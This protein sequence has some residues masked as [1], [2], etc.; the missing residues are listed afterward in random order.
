MRDNGNYNAFR[1]GQKSPETPLRPPSEQISSPRELIVTCLS[2]QQ[3]SRN[4]ANSRPPSPRRD[5][6]DTTR[7]CATSIATALRRRYTAPKPPVTPQQTGRSHRPTP[8]SHAPTSTHCAP[9]RPREDGADP[10]G[11]QLRTVEIPFKCASQPLHSKN[12]C[13][14]LNRHIPLSHKVQL[15]NGAWIAVVPTSWLT[16]QQDAE[17]RLQGGSY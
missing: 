14:I 4:P 12:T 1:I 8:S 10:T 2:P 15:E 7:D 16:L 5:R 9:P 13:T 6:P 17:L 3:Q 11:S